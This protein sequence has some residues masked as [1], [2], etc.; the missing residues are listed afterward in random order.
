MELHRM[1]VEQCAATRNIEKHF[2]TQQALNYLIGEKFLDFLEAADQS[3]AFRDEIP[4]FVA[5]IKVIFET[6]QLTAYLGPADEREIGETDESDQ[7]PGIVRCA[8]DPVLVERAR[9]YLLAD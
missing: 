6:W 7:K 4:A 9:R 2:G 3:D 1:W 5:E 8:S